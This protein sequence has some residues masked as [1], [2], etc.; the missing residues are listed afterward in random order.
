MG[1]SWGGSDYRMKG[2]RPFHNA[3]INLLIFMGLIAMLWAAF[4]VGQSKTEPTLDGSSDGRTHSCGY[5]TEEG[6]T[7]H[8]AAYKQRC[9]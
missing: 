7:E 8:L 4:M 2:Q 5:V 6:V 9:P 1:T 3:A